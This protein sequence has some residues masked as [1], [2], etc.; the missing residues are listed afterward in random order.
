MD[1]TMTILADGGPRHFEPVDREAGFSRF[2]GWPL[3]DLLEHFA[4][5]DDEPR[6]LDELV[7]MRTWRVSDCTRTSVEVTLRTVPG[8]VGRARLQPS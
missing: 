4:T 7:S 5:C 3:S 1:R 6:A 2:E 8:L